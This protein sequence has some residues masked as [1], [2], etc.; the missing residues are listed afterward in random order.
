MAKRQKSS[1]TA[2]PAM[3]EAGVGELLSY[4]DEDL[5]HTDSALVVRGIFDAMMRARGRPDPVPIYPQ[6]SIGES[7]G[8]VEA[9]NPMAR[10]KKRKGSETS[11]QKAPARAEDAP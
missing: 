9:L 2:T 4:S 6:V 5:Q 11:A 1:E 3:I 7:V 8:C 10:T